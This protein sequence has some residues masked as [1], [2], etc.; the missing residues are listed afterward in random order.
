MVR[1]MPSN[2]SEWEQLYRAA[3]LEP[4]PDRTEA[5]INALC[6]RLQQIRQSGPD[7]NERRQLEYAIRMLNLVRDVG[8]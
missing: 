8:L 4:S 1:D 3:V 2:I 5:A 6:K 7:T